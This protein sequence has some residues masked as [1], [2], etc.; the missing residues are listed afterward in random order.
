MATKKFP[1][2]VM[3]FFKQHGAAGGK[4]GGQIRAENM[5]A[6]QRSESARKAVLARWNRRKAEKPAD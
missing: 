1:P 2:Q 4:I 6:E 5:T 3:A